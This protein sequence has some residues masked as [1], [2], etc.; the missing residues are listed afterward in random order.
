[1]SSNLFSNRDFQK[2]WAGQG[3]SLFGTLTTRLVLPFLVIYTLSATPIQV[4]WV[5]VAEIAPGLAVGL[6]AGVAADRWPR[7]QV[8]LTA[9]FARA[10]LIGSIPVLFLAHRLS[11]GVILGAAACLSV[12]EMLFESAYDAFLPDLIPAE[13]L[14]DANAKISALGSMAEVSGFGLAGFLFEWLGGAMTFSVDALSFVASALSLW[15]IRRPEP[16]PSAAPPTRDRVMREIKDGLSLLH[17]NPILRRTAVVD[18]VNSA[19]FGLSAAV[20]MLYV[21]RDLHL[22]PVLQGLLYAVGGI[23]SLAT[24]GLTNKLVER[25]GLV[26]TI[27]AGALLA[28]VGTALLPLAFGPIWLLI[29]FVLGQQ[30]VGDGGDTLLAIGLTSLRQQHTDNRVLGR[31]RSVWLVLTGTGTLLGTLAGGQLA[32]MMGLRD[33]LF[34]GV[35]IRLLAALLAVISASVVATNIPP[36][37]AAHQEP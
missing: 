36:S 17:R 11:L 18:S 6:I 28:A 25:I 24:A 5:R 12:A 23:G 4:A 2:L 7:R 20:Y 10:A 19:F 8:M 26:R 29:I 13:Q 32:E 14:T 21:S 27:I 15:S 16:P 37:P 33:T 22:S 35:G 34:A 30:V 9:D 31:V 3:I 1:M